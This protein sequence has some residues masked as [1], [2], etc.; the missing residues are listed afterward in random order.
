M[1]V[2]GICSN[3]DYS[4]YRRKRMFDHCL[5]LLTT[6]MVGKRDQVRVI[7]MIW[8]SVVERY[9]MQFFLLVCIYTGFDFGLGV[10]R[11]VNT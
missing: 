3:V 1:L 8:L 4:L 5:S 9:M 7:I 11:C 6:G 10:K 2:N